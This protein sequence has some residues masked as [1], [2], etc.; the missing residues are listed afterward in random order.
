M[1]CVVPLK[2]E[3]DRAPTPSL[4]PPKP[5]QEFGKAVNHAVNF[6]PTMVPHSYPQYMS[7]INQ[8]HTANHTDTTVSTVQEKSQPSVTSYDA[9][10]KWVDFLRRRKLNFWLGF[11]DWGPVVGLR[12]FESYKSKNARR[13]LKGTRLIFEF[14]FCHRVRVSRTPPTNR[15]GPNT[16]KHVCSSSWR[17]ESAFNTNR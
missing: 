12:K 9:K 16:N 6:L 15:S 14:P 17:S 11:R 7:D 3:F 10:G 4:T 1:D 8:Q 13:G 5:V 2:S